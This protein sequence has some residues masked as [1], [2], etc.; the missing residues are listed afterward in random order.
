MEFFAQLHPKVVHF[1]VSLLLVY[2]LL[3]FIGVVFK[4]DF[5]SKSAHLILFLG[6][7]S[8][9]AAVLTGNQAFQVA[10]HWKN[11][12]AII[13]LSAINIHEE[14]AN[15]AMWFFTGV[16]V[17]RTIAVIKKKFKGYIKYSF[18]VLALVGA[19]FIYRAADLGGDLVYKY[20]IGTELKNPQ[21][22]PTE[23]STKVDKKEMIGSP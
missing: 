9:I 14:A 2:V 7:L 23:V 18:L 4:K 1:A 3:E 17:L 8:A 11:K 20:G 22:T 16:L 21:V 6:V 15:L 13:P 10:H 12:G 5:F 19:Y